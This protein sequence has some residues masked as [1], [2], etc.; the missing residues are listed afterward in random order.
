MRLS[1][2]VRFPINILTYVIQTQLNITAIAA[3]RDARAAKVSAYLQSMKNLIIKKVGDLGANLET[4]TPY[5]YQR[6]NIRERESKLRSLDQSKN[7][8]YLDS[9]SKAIKEGKIL[10]DVYG[11]AAGHHHGVVSCI[12]SRSGGP[13]VSSS[14]VEVVS[15]PRGACIQVDTMND[16]YNTYSAHQEVYLFLSWELLCY[17]YLP[18]TCSMHVNEQL[19]QSRYYPD[20]LGIDDLSSAS[21]SLLLYDYHKGKSIAELLKA[22]S[23]RLTES[24][25]LFKYWAREI[26]F[27]LADF[28]QMSTFTLDTMP[29]LSNIIVSEGGSKLLIGKLKLGRPLGGWETTGNI[30]VLSKQSKDLMAAYGIM[31]RGML[32]KGKA[33]VLHR[34]IHSSGEYDTYGIEA[35]NENDVRSVINV[36]KGETFQIQLKAPSNCEIVID[37]PV[38][39][40]ID[41]T[42]DTCLVCLNN[43]DKNAFNEKERLYEFYFKGLEPGEC[44]V[45]FFSRFRFEHQSSVILPTYEFKV[46]VSTTT[47]SPTLN[48]LITASQL[49]FRVSLSDE[50]VSTSRP[51]QTN[52]NS[53]ATNNASSRLDNNTRHSSYH[54]I[55]DVVANTN[56]VSF[57]QLVH[58]PYFKFNGD[59]CD[60]SKV[61]DCFESIFPTRR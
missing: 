24:N 47:L 9:V 15:V 23:L 21:Y 37:R 59:D 35:Y 39:E 45:K 30:E 32:C 42:Q 36:E 16:L 4:I 54:E 2:F 13:S 6:Q 27:A 25:P 29:N 33:D 34:G 57:V 51:N 40:T 52:I 28:V 17:L 41:A 49:Y 31:L 11:H 1:I 3:E 20:V 43:D 5:E 10:R 60:V 44:S 8:L 61:I 26:L 46:H 38:I 19:I 7:S 56:Q 48:A 50:G 22:N 53:N 58:H 14:Q 18:N 55:Y 12:V